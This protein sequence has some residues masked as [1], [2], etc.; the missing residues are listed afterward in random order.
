MKRW[1]YRLSCPRVLASPH[2]G[3]CIQFKN[4]WLEIS[5]GVIRISK[6]YAWDGCSPAL[7]V[8]FT[9]L[10]L[11]VPD[12]TLRESGRPVA[13]EA[14]LYH[15]ALCQFRGEIQ[16]L[17]KQMATAVFVERLEASGAPW[18]MRKTYGAAV[19]LLGPQNFQGDL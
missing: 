19:D 2:I 10:W 1:R 4:E 9:H 17:T 13:W 11:G 12:G 5:G 15:D 6:G 8:P 14:S 18:A 16:G 7:K 3:R